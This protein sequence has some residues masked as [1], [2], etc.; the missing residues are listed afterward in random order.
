MQKSVYNL[1]SMS[2]VLLENVSVCSSICINLVSSP[3]CVATNRSVKYLN[4][5]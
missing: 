4:T 1:I 2:V 5:C 3:H